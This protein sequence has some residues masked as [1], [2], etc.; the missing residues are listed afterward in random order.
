MDPKHEHPQHDELEE[1]GDDRI[2]SRDAPVPR[3]L[4][5]NY[6]IWPIFGVV[7]FYYFFNGSYGW[8]D[9]GYW[10][11]LQ[12]A[13][14]TTYPYDNVNIPYKKVPPPVKSDGK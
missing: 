3:W 5:V 1:Y 9:R 7:W 13:A 11:E 4:I 10:Q 6:I 2:A 12:R 8:L 14:N